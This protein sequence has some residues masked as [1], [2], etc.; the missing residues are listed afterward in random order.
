MSALS[1]RTNDISVHSLWIQKAVV[2]LFY[3]RIFSV[4]PAAARIIAIYWIVLCATYLAAQAAC[5][6]DCVP[7]RLY[8]QVVPNPGK[9]SASTL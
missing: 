8:W 7:L 4:L 5:V 6:L 1:H 3:R 2:L 9:S